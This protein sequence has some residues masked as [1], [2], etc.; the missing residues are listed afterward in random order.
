MKIPICHSRR[1][2]PS[3]TDMFY[4]LHPKM[5]VLDH[6]VSP[7]ICKMCDL[8]HLPAP[9]EFRPMPNPDGQFRRST[10]CFHFGEPNGTREC[11]GCGKNVRIKVFHCHHA[12]H[13]ETTIEECANC[14]DYQPQL[15][16]G[17]VKTWAVGMTTAPRRQSTI[18][19]TLASLSD[20]GW[21]QLRLFAEPGSVIPE[22]NLTLDVSQRDQTLGAFHN[23]YLGLMELWLRQPSA[24]A[25]FI[26]QDDVLFS[27]GLRKYL[28]QQLWPAPRLGVVSVYCPS[29]YSRPGEWGFHIETHGKHTFGALAYVFSNVSLREFLWHSIVITHCRRELEYGRAHIDSI[30]GE[31]SLQTGLP[32]FVHSPSLSQHIGDTSTINRD[33]SN[34]GTRRAEFFP[35]E[36][37]SL[38]WQSELR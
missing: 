34:T 11:K 12:E 35:V 36:I 8:Q 6:L 16:S 30:V 37:E 29:H 7:Q 1:P 14:P 23:W 13:T 10:R 26:C 33:S 38:A 22:A 3:A 24:D 28:E 19:E 32:Y 2:V 4:C 21:N 15:K 27:K 31:W 17:T 5:N 25:Y 18:S 20:A 9:L